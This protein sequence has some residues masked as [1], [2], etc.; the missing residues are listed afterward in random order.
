MVCPSESE[1]GHDGREAPVDLTGLI[2]KE[3]TDRLERVHVI[4]NDLDDHRQ[5]EH[6]KQDKARPRIP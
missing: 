3:M 5:E 4:A 2:A 1:L 6:K